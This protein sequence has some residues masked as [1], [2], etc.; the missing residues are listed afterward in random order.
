MLAFLNFIFCLAAALRDCSSRAHA[1]QRES[2]VLLSADGNR[3]F[4]FY[5][6]AVSGLQNPA[7]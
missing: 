7:G 2:G 4:V 3:G 5:G 6:G 1:E